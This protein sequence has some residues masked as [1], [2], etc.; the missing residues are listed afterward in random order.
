MLYL[1]LSYVPLSIVKHTRRGCFGQT[2]RQL[3]AKLKLKSF[4]TRPPNRDAAK[5]HLLSTRWAIDRRTDLCGSRLRP[6]RPLLQ[7]VLDDLRTDVRPAGGVVFGPPCDAVADYRSLHTQ[8]RTL[9]QPNGVRRKR[10]LRVRE[11]KKR[12]RTKHVRPN[13]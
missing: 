11:K 9:G 12:C 6:A 4:Q 3:H 2:S 8:N 1:L 7:K 5:R 10:G 13:L